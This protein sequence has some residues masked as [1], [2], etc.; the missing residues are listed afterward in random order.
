MN[1]AMPSFDLD[2]V[3]SRFPGLATPTV[4]MDNAAGALVCA[5][6]IDAVGDCLRFS[7][8]QALGVDYDHAR[9]VGERYRTA[10]RRLAELI[11]APDPA[12]VVVGPS[13]TVL[14][15]TLARG[16][17]PTLR[18]GDEIVVTD[19]DHEANI[20]PWERVAAATGAVV[21]TWRVRRQDLR[22]DLAELAGLL[23]RRTRLVCAT[24]CSNVLGTVNP[25]RAIADLAHAHGALLCVD[26]VAYA[27]HGPV[28]VQALGADFYVLSFYKLYGPH[29]AALWGRK[30]LLEGL[31]GT[32]HAFIPED[33]VPYKFQPGNPNYE[34]T[35]GSAAV[36]DYLEALGRRHG[37]GHEAP[38]P[39]Q[40][41]RAFEVIAEQEERL[42][43][44]LLRYLAAHPS[45]RILGE[46]TADRSVRVP[47][48]SF[49]VEGA[50]SGEV[51]RGLG[52]AGVG[53]RAG[54]FYAKRLH[55]ALGG[56]RHGGFVRI[57]LLHYNTPAEVNHLLQAL[58]AVVEEA[59]R[60][61]RVSN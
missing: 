7:N 20:G 35:V 17:A 55:D 31:K 51:A 27:P 61:R 22:F 4:L 45:V 12:E 33:E 18:P 30:T 58:D 46:D 43:G 21:R 28:D 25:V 34:L 23:G 19:V 41:E 54:N 50:D 11:N 6:V 8:V 24:H 36:V 26:G 53:A 42:A 56:E 57:S 52:R 3:R 44:P 59:K 2:W 14:F 1:A 15:D 5:D 48:V 29:H 16:F 49:V 38:P 37:S 10:H 39:R 13:A 47:T 9:S 32:N 60:G 40:R